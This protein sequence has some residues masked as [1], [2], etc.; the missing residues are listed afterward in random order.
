MMTEGSHEV[1]LK[2]VNLALNRGNRNI[3]FGKASKTAGRQ[4]LKE[5]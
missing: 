5:D 2:Q 4:M 3:S 1:G